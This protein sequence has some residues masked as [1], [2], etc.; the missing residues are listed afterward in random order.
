MIKKCT[1]VLCIIIYYAYEMISALVVVRVSNIESEVELD[2]KSAKI[3][4]H[5]QLKEHEQ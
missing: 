4:V 1:R 2:S 3:P 5:E